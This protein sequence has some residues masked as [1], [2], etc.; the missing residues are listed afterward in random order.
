MSDS[1]YAP[2]ALIDPS[3]PGAGYEHRAVRGGDARWCAATA[4]LWA[5]D[6]ERV[7]GRR[8]NE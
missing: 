1:R 6:E 3:D 4:L 2:A 5:R 7:A 8:T